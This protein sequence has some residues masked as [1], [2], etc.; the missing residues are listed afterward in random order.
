VT[1]PTNGDIRYYRQSE[2]SDA[3]LLKQNVEDI[4]GPNQISLS[5]LDISK[6]FPNLPSGIMEVWI[7]DLHSGPKNG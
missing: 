3:K 1:Q 2:A 4:I 6:T 5:V 7:P